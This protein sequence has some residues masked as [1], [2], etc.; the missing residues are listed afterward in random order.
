MRV[1][2]GFTM[3][4]VGAVQVSHA[5]LILPANPQGRLKLDEVSTFP[6][7]DIMTGMKTEWCLFDKTH[8]ANKV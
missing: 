3:T 8:S 4:S 2:P 7:P 5:S 1:C 6:G